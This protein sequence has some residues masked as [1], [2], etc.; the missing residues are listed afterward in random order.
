M[1]CGSLYEEGGLRFAICACYSWN[2]ELN[3]GLEASFDYMYDWK[4]IRE[5]AVEVRVNSATNYI[6]ND[7]TYG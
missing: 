6:T 7:V 4:G 5:K 1:N 3:V 2:M